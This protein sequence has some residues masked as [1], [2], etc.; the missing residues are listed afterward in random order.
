MTLQLISG[1]FKK[2]E[3]RFKQLRNPWCVH[4][5]LFN[6]N[7]EEKFMNTDISNIHC[8]NILKYFVDFTQVQK[9]S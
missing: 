4:I 3:V 9:L 6:A 7:F 1:L 2:S 5:L 8:K